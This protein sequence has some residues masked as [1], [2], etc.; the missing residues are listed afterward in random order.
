MTGPGVG[1]GHPFEQIAVSDVDPH[2]GPQ[3]GVQHQHGLIGEERDAEDQVG[4][5]KDQVG[6]HGSQVTALGDPPPPRQQS[7]EHGQRGWHEH[8]GQDEP[9][10][11][12][13]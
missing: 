6:G 1:C 13:G 12:L 8:R 10:P 3:D 2:E 11:Q 4:G 5:G 9:G 7:R